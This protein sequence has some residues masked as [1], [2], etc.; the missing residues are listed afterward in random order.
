MHTNPVEVIG[1]ERTTTAGPFPVR[2]KHE[3][4][5]YQLASA[6]E[7]LGQGPLPLRPFKNIILLYFDPGQFPALPAQ[8]ISETSK[9]F[10]L[11]QKLFSR[12]EPFVCRNDLVVIEVCLDHI[13]ISLSQK[14]LVNG[15]LKILSA[16]GP[17]G[18][19]RAT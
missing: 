14:S 6:L 15:Q 2:P 9:L 19:K 16:G 17:V 13:V 7:Q 5:D 12:L 8:L 1:P 10:L 18:P 4:I 3:M 11:E